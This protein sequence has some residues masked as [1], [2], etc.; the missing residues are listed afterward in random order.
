MPATGAFIITAQ[1]IF[2]LPGEVRRRSHRRGGCDLQ[3]IDFAEP[4]RR[5]AFARDSED[6]PVP[7]TR[8]PEPADTEMGARS[9]SRS[10]IFRAG[11]VVGWR[12]ERGHPVCKCEG[13]LALT[14]ATGTS[15]A[16]PCRCPSFM[17]L[18]KRSA[19]ERSAVPISPSFTSTGTSAGG[20][21]V[22]FRSTRGRTM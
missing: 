21:A 11:D 8:G 14:S 19:T 17:S 20:C 2:A 5:N 1:Q 15:R 4:A 22:V 3:Q 18:R 7:G 6:G 9:E 13:A 12:I 10:A 16:S